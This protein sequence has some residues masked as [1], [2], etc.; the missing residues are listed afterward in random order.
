MCRLVAS[1]E[2]LHMLTVCPVW[3]SATKG[4]IFILRVKVPYLRGSFPEELASCKVVSR[5]G[6]TEESRTAKPGT[7]VQ[8]LHMRPVRLDKA[9]HLVNVRT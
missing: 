8:K 3:A 7:D 1:A 6:Y 5:E 4:S 9:A 2:S